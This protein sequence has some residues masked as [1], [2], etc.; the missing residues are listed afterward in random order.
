VC[1]EISFYEIVGELGVIFA[2]IISFLFNKDKYFFLY[3]ETIYQIINHDNRIYLDISLHLDFIIYCLLCANL[4]L[5]N[6]NFA[7]DFQRIFLS[8][9]CG[10]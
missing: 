6:P 7:K 1:E 10:A 9:D 2:V 3:I 8:R 5:E 4:F